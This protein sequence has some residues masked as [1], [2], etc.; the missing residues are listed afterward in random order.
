MDE[1]ETVPMQAS[2]KPKRAIATE[3]AKEAYKEYAEQ[4]G[5][6]QSFERLHQRGGFGDIEI[7]WLLYNRIQ[8][9]EGRKITRIF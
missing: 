1:P 3:I 4:F 7:I 5:A 8:R 6:D 2:L 9:L